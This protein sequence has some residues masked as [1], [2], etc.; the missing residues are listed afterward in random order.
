MVRTN[1]WPKE[2]K[3]IIPKN[4]RDICEEEYNLFDKNEYQEIQTDIAKKL[5]KL[6][7]TF[8]EN[9]KVNKSYRV[10]FKLT[11]SNV[12]KLPTFYSFLTIFTETDHPER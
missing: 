4:A 3:D 5:L 12:T 9:V 2:Y 7:V 10:D 1:L 8:I 11:D 6:R